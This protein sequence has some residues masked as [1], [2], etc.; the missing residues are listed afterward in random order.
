MRTRCWCEQDAEA[1]RNW[2][3]KRSTCLCNCSSQ[4]CPLWSPVSGIQTL[5]FVGSH[6]KW[7]S[8]GFFLFFS[9]FLPQYF[10]P[11]SLTRIASF[12]NIRPRIVNGFFYVP[13]S[14]PAFYPPKLMRRNKSKAEAGKRRREKISHEFFPFISKKHFRHPLWNTKHPISVRRFRWTLSSFPL[15]LSLPFRPIHPLT[16]RNPPRP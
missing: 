13:P 8:V 6:A 10:V 15:F 14:R 1:L 3:L 4:S 7:K 16:R 12:K 2:T 5:Q 9:Y 11:G